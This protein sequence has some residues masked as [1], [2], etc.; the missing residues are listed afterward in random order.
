RTGRDGPVGATRKPG[1]SGGRTC[2][3]G[4]F[5]SVSSP[6][7]HQGRGCD[8]RTAAV[9]GGLQF[10]RPTVSLLLPDVAPNATRGGPRPLGWK[11]SEARR[12]SGSSCASKLS[13][14]QKVS[15]LKSPMTSIPGKRGANRS[16]SKPVSYV[17]GANKR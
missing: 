15:P 10:A 1:G 14:G 11:P 5:G 13:Q 3:Q 6:K 7:S 12:P 8:C 16:P 2:S 9:P 17:G 4:V